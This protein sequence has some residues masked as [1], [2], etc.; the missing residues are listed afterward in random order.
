[1]VWLVQGKLDVALADCSQAL[2]SGANDSSAYSLR[3]Q[4]WLAK[5]D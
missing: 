2:A 4:V 3:G 1:L 5:N